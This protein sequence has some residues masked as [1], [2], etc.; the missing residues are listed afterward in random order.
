MKFVYELKYL[1][2]IWQRN[3]KNTIEK[4]K[5]AVQYK[6]VLKQL[7]DSD[8]CDLLGEE[9]ELPDKY[10]PESYILRRTQELDKLEDKLYEFACQYRRENVLGKD[11][12]ETI[13]KYKKDLSRMFFIGNWSCEPDIESQLTGEDMPQFYHDYWNENQ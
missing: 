4:E 9:H 1:A 6:Q 12:T 10:L 2:K 5:I 11:N 13:K 3:L 8:W 7:E